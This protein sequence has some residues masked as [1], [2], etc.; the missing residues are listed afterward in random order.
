MI[1]KAAMGSIQI[2]ASLLPNGPAIIE[3][4]FALT[5][6]GSQGRLLAI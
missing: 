1:L 2:S 5:I 4:T 3:A 6:S